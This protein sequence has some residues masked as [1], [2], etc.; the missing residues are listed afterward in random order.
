MLWS[1]RKVQKLLRLLERSILTLRKASSWPRWW[2]S[3]TSKKRAVKLQPRCELLFCF[4][5]FCLF[6]FPQPN[7]SWVAACAEF[8][9][10]T[11]IILEYINYNFFP[12]FLSLSGCWQVQATGQ[13]LHCGGR[14]HYLFQ[15]QHTQRTQKEIRPQSHWVGGI[16][17]Q[18][19]V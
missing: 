12:L 9:S 19:T 8:P 6:V 18:N 2:S 14:G 5:C 16:K 15:I 13:E 1:H 4:G 11:V 3:Q 10:I 17:T 7:Y